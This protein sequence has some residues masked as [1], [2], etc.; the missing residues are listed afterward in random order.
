VPLSLSPCA[1]SVTLTVP[2]GET[3]STSIQ[4][5]ATLGRVSATARTAEEW[6]SL[7]RV[8]VL[9][10][11]IPALWFGMLTLPRPVVDAV[12]LFLGGYVLLLAVGPRWLRIL[13]KA[14]LVV[15]LDLGVVTLIVLASGSASSPFLY[16]YYL[17]I[18]EAACRFNLRQAVAASMA[19]ASVAVMLWMREGHSEALETV[20][21]RL[22]ASVAGGFFLSLLLGVLVQEYRTS[23]DRVTELVFD[24]DLVTRLSGELRVNGVA[25][26]LLR[27]FSDV[28]RLPKAAVYIPDNRGGL[29]C[30]AAQGFTPQ[31]RDPSPAHL[32]VPP[33]PDG[34]R[35]GDIIAEPCPAGSGHPG[36]VM[37]CVP[38]IHQ[39][40]LQMWVCGLS[41]SAPPLPDLVRRHLRSL[42]AHGVSA[43]EAARLHERV[44]EL[45][46]TDA[47]TGV[48]NRRSF[49]DRVAVELARSHRI[50]RALSIALL[51]LNRFKSIND[52]YG[53][54]VGDEALVRVAEALSKGI[55]ASDLVA[56]LGG[57]EFAVL[58]PN[59]D[60]E[61]A[62]RALARLA[63][64]AVSTPD[65]RGGALH[66]TLSWGTA[67]WP[68]DGASPEQLLH[69]ADQRLYLMKKQV[70]GET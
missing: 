47:L 19:M 42:A 64:A 14:D 41:P 2:G 37:V 18:L 39:R 67:T 36:G 4:L 8:L 34:A 23:H 40:R 70:Q 26:L 44:A 25:E 69:A 54:N 33:L 12:V 57:D 13:Q 21:F 43:L 7:V 59:T 29:T 31:E 46:A 51:D 24:N 55:R 32:V 11:L 27:V 22:G 10:G 20:G 28:T 58:L 38:L 3:R 52:G 56:R 60:G 5:V 16:L 48:A 49:F 65:G 66:L 1:P 62:V 6:V 63:G 35:C 68:H 50:G 45:A 30:V 53:H 15:V 61:A 9:L 17:I